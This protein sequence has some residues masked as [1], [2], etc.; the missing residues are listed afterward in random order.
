MKTLFG[1][2]TLY[3]SNPL[4]WVWRT[5]VRGRPNNPRPHGEMSPDSVFSPLN[6]QVMIHLISRF[7]LQAR[8]KND[9]CYLHLSE[10]KRLLCLLDYLFHLTFASQFP[11][12]PSH[13]FVCIY[14]QNRTSI[15]HSFSRPISRGSC[16]LWIL[17]NQQ[18]AE[19][20]GRDKRLKQW[21]M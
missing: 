9:P 17:R 5:Q 20:R 2:V 14:G 3:L 12:H 6:D 21:Q 1:L 7:K 18:A 13:F 4:G 15:F 8:V 19:W 10:D 16:A 11:N